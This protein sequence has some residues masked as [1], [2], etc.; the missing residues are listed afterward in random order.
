MN[1]SPIV[2]LSISLLICYQ[3]L[4]SNIKKESI[5]T[6]NTM[7]NSTNNSIGIISRI[8]Y[9]DIQNDLVYHD[10]GSG[11]KITNNSKVIIKQLNLDLN[12]ETAVI[13]VINLETN[14]ALKLYD[15]KPNQNILYTPYSDG[16]YKIIAETSNGKII[17]LTPMAGVETALTENNTGGFILLH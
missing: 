3:N 7:S 8:D 10:Y 4:G 6:D 1:K 11:I 2:I 12:D 5:S 13:Y 15:Y 17:D 16:V 9:S 14:Y